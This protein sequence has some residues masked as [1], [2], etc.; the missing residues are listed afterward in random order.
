V[1]AASQQTP[2]VQKPL[3]HWLFA[4]QVC[5]SAAVRLDETAEGG[6][7]AGAGCRSSP[8]H[9]SKSEASTQVQP[10]RLFMS[11]LPRAPRR[12][13]I[14]RLVLTD[15]WPNLVADFSG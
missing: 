6:A 10:T 12:S 7:F 3:A 11:D 4:V 14:A 8:P 1:Q 9:A 13:A 15:H 2:S 5:S